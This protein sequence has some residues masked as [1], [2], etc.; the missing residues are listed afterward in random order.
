[1]EITKQEAF[2]KTLENT[3]HTEVEIPTKGIV[4]PK[5]H[6]LSK[7]SV[8]LRYMIGE[9]EEILSS[10]ASLKNIPN[11][12]SNLLKRLV[13]IPNF[14]VDDLTQ[15]DKNYLILAS[16][17]AS[18]GDEYMVEEVRCPVC[19]HVEKNH[20]FSLFDIKESEMTLQPD[21]PHMNKFT[22]T[23]P[24]SEQTVVLKM[25]T[26]K[27]Q[28]EMNTFKESRGQNVNDLSLAVAICIDEFPNMPE[29]PSIGNKIAFYRK[30]PMKDT[31][32]LRKIIKKINFASEYIID[33]T[34]P[35][36]DE[37]TE[38]SLILDFSFFFP[39]I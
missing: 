1:M 38:K 24:A 19:G 31:N 11:A 33:Y 37:V 34:C 29:N 27:D 12:Y 39:E 16:R 26:V 2:K 6:P 18:L 3:P 8:P 10:P 36:C 5:D 20:T 25:N 15:Q 32:Y 9:D 21:K 7:G 30:L 22:V 28:R 4:Y 23:L 35:S 13:L 17:V 14:N